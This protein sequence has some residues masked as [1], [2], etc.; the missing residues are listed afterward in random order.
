MIIAL[1][2]YAQSGKDAAAKIIKEL[3]PDFE[4]KRFSGKLKQVA[5]IL[6]GIPEARFEDQEFK[7]SF[8]GE[9]WG[10]VQPNPLN[11]IDPFTDIEFNTLMSVRELLQKLGTDAIRNGL[12]ANAWV[13][14]LMVDY[15]AEEHPG[16]KGFNK[17]MLPPSKWVIADCRFSNEAVAVKSKGGIVVR[18]ERPGVEPVNSHPSETA[19]DGWKFD[20]RIC[21]DGTLDD[22]KTKLETLLNETNCTA[23]AMP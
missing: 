22:L 3:D 21:N 18:I 15:K 7:K 23:S 16:F 4:I 6:T 13:N 10:T 5:S 12:H 19:L 1:S 2:G 9:E 11:T 20:Y 14:A 17:T 8:L